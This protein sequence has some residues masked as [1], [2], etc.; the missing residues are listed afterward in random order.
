MELKWET[1]GREPEKHSVSWVNSKCKMSFRCTLASQAS[2]NYWNSEFLPSWSVVFEQTCLA[3][4]D[5]SG[6]SDHHLLSVLETDLNDIY[7]RVPELL[8][9]HL[10][11]LIA[12]FPVGSAITDLD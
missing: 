11:S 10:S 4:S 1:I 3:L 2:L 9:L 7:C 8:K 12:L 5:L 6:V